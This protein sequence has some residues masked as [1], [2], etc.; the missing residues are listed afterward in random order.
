MIVLRVFVPFAFGY[1][2]SYMYRVINAVIAPELIRD[3]GVDASAL[4]LLTAAYFLASAS[5]QIPLGI[6]LDRFGPRRTEAALLTFA[7]AGAFVFASADGTALLIL[8]RALIGFG[9]SACLMAAFKAYR[10]WFQEDRL[11]FVNGCQMAVGGLGA[12][13]AT[14]PVDMAL[15]LAGW[16]EVFMAIG[17]LTLL[18]AVIIYVVVP[19]RSG[20]HQ[21]GEGLV[22]QL[23]GVARVFTSPVFWRIV[24][25][26]VATHAT[27]FAIQGLWAGPWL[28]DVAGLT[29]ASIGNYLLLIACAMVAGFLV[30]GALAERLSRIGISVVT[31]AVTGMVIFMLLQ[32]VLVVQWTGAL[33]PLWVL[34]GVF[35]TVGILPY[36]VLPA[37][38][39]PHLSGRVITSINLV[40]F[41]SAFVV[42]WAMGIIINLWPAAATGAYAPVGYQAA[43]GT[44]LAIQVATLIW[45]CLFR[46]GAARDL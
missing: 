10:I 39:P 30:M 35:G 17:A 24:P 13:S 23:R 25:V 22:D 2:L 6:L 37:H 29:R 36:A 42:Q 1:F 8:G 7:A 31:V 43:F 38:F 26:I 46:R 16:R 4:G 27:F 19:E 45:F 15:G 40:V 20:R 33:V 9:V 3:V 14:R 5:F 32:L 11:P 21:S 41:L 34:F 28:K 44:M 18:A 12:L